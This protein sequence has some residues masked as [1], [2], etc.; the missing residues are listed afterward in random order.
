MTCPNSKVILCVTKLCL[1][2]A[3]NGFQPRWSRSG[4]SEDMPGFA[5]AL[6]QSRFVLLRPLRDSLLV[7]DVSFG[8]LIS[9][10]LKS[11]RMR[12]PFWWTFSASP[13]PGKFATESSPRKGLMSKHI[14][15]PRTRYFRNCSCSILFLVHFHLHNPPFVTQHFQLRSKIQYDFKELKNNRMAFRNSLLR[16]VVTFAAGYHNCQ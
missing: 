11:R 14:T 10:T 8:G 7:L 16:H 6:S 9:Q 5:R 2:S 1:F 3:S 15:L 4:C 13:L 12:T